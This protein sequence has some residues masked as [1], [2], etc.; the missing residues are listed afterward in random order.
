MRSIQ[1][2]SLG[3][4][5]YNVIQSFFELIRNSLALY[6]KLIIVESVV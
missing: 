6:R 5:P 1:V 4:T 2:N 3:V